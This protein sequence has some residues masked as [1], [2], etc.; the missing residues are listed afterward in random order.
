MSALTIQNWFDKYAESHQNPTNKL[1]HWV[2]V[3][4]IFFTLIGLASQLNFSSIL[5]LEESFLANYFH[6]GSIIILLGILF[7]IRLS[8]PIT[9][10]MLLISALV[11]WGVEQLSTMEIMPFWI[12]CLLV[13]TLA[14]IGQFIGHKIEGKKPS[15]IEDVQFLMVGPGWL[16]SFI[17]KKL[18]IPY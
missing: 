18:G 3:P 12:F 16:L 6:F 14:W 7:Y 15:F 9:I 1:V 2:C 5:G 10:G 11:L 13:F 8:I 4:A 17:Y